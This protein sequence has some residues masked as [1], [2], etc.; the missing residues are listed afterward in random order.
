MKLNSIF[1]GLILLAFSTFSFGQKKAD[2]SQNPID[3]QCDACLDSSENQNTAGM[4]RC[5]VNAEV[6]WDKEMNKYYKLLMQKLNPE[7][8]EKLKTAQKSWLQYRD[9]EI[10]FSNKLHTDM[11]GTMWLVVNAGRLAEI[12]KQRALELKGYYDEF[13]LH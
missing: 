4:I 5:S 11:E 2:A 1:L 12:V 13:E 8:K 9:N 10:L 7:E 3:K 6:A